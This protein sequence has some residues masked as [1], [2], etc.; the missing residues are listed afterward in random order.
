MISLLLMKRD[1]KLCYCGGV[2]TFQDFRLQDPDLAVDE[3]GKSSASYFFLQLSKYVMVLDFS[4]MDPTY[5]FWSDV[6]SPQL[7]THIIG[8]EGSKI[9]PVVVFHSDL[10]SRHN[11]VED[12]AIDVKWSDYYTEKQSDTMIGDVDSLSN[13]IRNSRDGDIADT[14]TDD[15]TAEPQKPSLEMAPVIQAR[16]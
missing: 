11:V 8:W 12:S 16:G 4:S 14:S 15:D 3:T 13:R 6:G 2:D 1:R 7:E 9:I 5:S 10:R